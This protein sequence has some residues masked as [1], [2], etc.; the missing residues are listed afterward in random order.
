MKKQ[1]F[2]GSGWSKLGR[3]FG[4]KSIKNRSQDRV[5]PGMDFWWNFGG[6]GEPSWGWK[7]T[8]N[9]FQKVWK[10]ASEQESKTKRTG[11]VLSHLGRVFGWNGWGMGGV[12][13]CARTAGGDTIRPPKD[14]FSRHTQTHLGLGIWQCARARALAV[15]TWARARAMAVWTLTL[16]HAV[17]RERGG[18]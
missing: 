18:G 4:R 7:S 10:H 13:P 11:G 14:Q 12:R 9:R 16:T 2:W 1:H 5:R 3:K 15:W 6:F 17:A 8:R